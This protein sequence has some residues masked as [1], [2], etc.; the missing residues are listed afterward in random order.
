MRKPLRDRARHQ[1]FADHLKKTFEPREGLYDMMTADTVVCR[2]EEVTAANI[3][4]IASEWNGS[5]RA[6]KQCTRAGMGQCQG[7]ICESV[8]VQIAARASGRSPESV[9]RDTARHQVKPISLHALAEPVGA[10]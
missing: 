7:R 3:R 9:G 1:S 6:I 10:A 5:L 4:A 8:V 2:C